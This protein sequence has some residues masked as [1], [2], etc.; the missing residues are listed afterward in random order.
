M[1][2]IPL[3][4][5]NCFLLDILIKY[6][7]FQVCYIWRFYVLKKSKTKQNKTNGMTFQNHKRKKENKNKGKNI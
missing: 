7:L 2:K 3:Q 5:M 6:Y 1:H 4:Q